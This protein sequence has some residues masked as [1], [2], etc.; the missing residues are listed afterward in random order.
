MR[1]VRCPGADEVSIR[2]GATT[3][4]RMILIQGAGEPM[5]VPEGVV[6]AR[7]AGEGFIHDEVDGTRLRISAGAFFQSS[8]E[9]AAALVRSVRSSL[10]GL[11][12]SGVLLDAY[13]GGGLF[14]ATVGSD[15]IEAG[16]SV[17]GVESNPIAVADAL[18][19]APAATSVVSRFERWNPVAVDAV[20]ADPAR[21][22]LESAGVAPIAATG[23]PVVVL[24][25]CD[26]G[27]LGCDAGLLLAA[28]YRIS[29]VEVLDLFNQTSHAEVVTRFVRV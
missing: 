19:N 27:A 4:E 18:V 14:S 17:L 28:G 24:V 16:G 3:S 2:V 7:E 25:S 1:T 20:I 23:A 9:G 29:N 6:V 26:V 8:P 10:E 5:N 12:Q 22:G 15:W 11:D 21:S 13:A